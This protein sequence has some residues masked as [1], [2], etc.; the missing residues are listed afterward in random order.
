MTTVANRD[1]KDSL[2]CSILLIAGIL[3]VP[4]QGDLH[5]YTLMYTLHSLE[6]QLLSCPQRFSDAFH[7]RVKRAY[8]RH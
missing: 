1:P 5:R 2:N 7:D 4:S 8:D 6:G 3:R